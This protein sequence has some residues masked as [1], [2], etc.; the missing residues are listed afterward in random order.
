M[1]MVMIMMTKD[2]VANL[3]QLHRM[4]RRIEQ[5]ERRT[6]NM[7]THNRLPQS[8]CLIA[9]NAKNLPIIGWSVA[10]LWL[11]ICRLWW[12]IPIVW[13]GT[14][15]GWR[16]QKHQT[17]DKKSRSMTLKHTSLCVTVCLCVVRQE[18]EAKQHVVCLTV[19]VGLT[20]Q[21]VLR[22]V[23]TSTTSIHN[24]RVQKFNWIRPYFSTS[25]R[26]TLVILETECNCVLLTKNISASQLS[27]TVLVKHFCFDY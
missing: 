5:Q 1:I 7:E 10:C 25:H 16:S 22:P 6:C 15:K 3:F 4:E 14:G 21:D 11:L 2:K 20:G 19:G 13:S 23:Y 12:S 27:E 17:T 24:T 9:T 18:P 26:L 8:P